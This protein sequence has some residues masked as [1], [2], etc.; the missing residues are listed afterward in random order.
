VVVVGY[1]SERHV[2]LLV[3]LGINW[4]VKLVQ[5]LGDWLAVQI[6]ATLGTPAGLTARGRWLLLAMT[7]AGLVGA[8]RPLHASRAGHHAAG[9]WLAKHAVPADTIID[10]FAWAHY[11]AGR[12]FLEDRPPV[13]PPGYRPMEYAVLDSGSVNP[14]QPPPRKLVQLFG[15][16]LADGAPERTEN[17]PRLPLMTRAKEVRGAGGQLVYY[18]PE[19][20]PCD[21]AKVFIYA[22][23]TP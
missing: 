13:V 18:W 3:L 16:S 7:A 14:T 2:L 4:G 20:V 5:G 8:L 6:P 11:Y 10:P 17:H 1:L 21:R 19:D 15:P 22:R 12:V 23:P 9:T